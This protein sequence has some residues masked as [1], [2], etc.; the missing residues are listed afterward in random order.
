MLIINTYG[1]CRIQGGSV[2]ALVC[3]PPAQAA[4]TLALGREARDGVVLGARSPRLESQRGHALW[5][6]QHL[7]LSLLGS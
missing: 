6:K 7:W 4:H 5:F 3:T 2:Q 1:E